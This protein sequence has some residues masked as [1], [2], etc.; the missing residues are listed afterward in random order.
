MS[1]PA[2]TD[3]KI[4]FVAGEVSEPF[5]TLPNIL[6]VSMTISLICFFLMNL[7]IYVVL[8]LKTVRD[9]EAVAVVFGRTLLGAVGAFCYSFV[10]S[11]S[12]LGS[13]NSNVFSTGRLGA[14]A[15]QR[16]YL[17]ALFAPPPSL[18]QD[19]LE[20]ES[21]LNRELRHARETLSS[22]YF[23][24]VLITVFSRVIRG[25]FTLR[26]TQ[27]PV[28]AMVLNAAMAS[29]YIAMG[30]FGSLITFIGISMYLIYFFC[31][32]GIFVLRR[33]ESHPKGIYVA[34]TY[35]VICFIFLSAFVV[36]RGVASQPTQGL[37]ILAAVAVGYV[38]SRRIVKS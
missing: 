38:M 31:V 8:P 4:G 32:V 3:R 15:A 6:N 19:P 25:T 27:V 21:D 37:A 7:A 11:M 10:V 36:L 35:C 34:P 29:I 24:G 1:S 26:H 33:R 17:P 9:N 20:Q 2:K 13:L 12:A 16:R 22:Y 23:P 28:N 18:S 30:T 14:V 5:R